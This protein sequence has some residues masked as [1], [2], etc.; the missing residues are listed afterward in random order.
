MVYI[1][2]SIMFRYTVK[3]T[4]TYHVAARNYYHM[5]AQA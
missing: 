1:T 4:S 5:Y 3:Y 2:L